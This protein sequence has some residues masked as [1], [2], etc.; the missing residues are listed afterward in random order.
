MTE[1]TEKIV[2][3]ISEIPPG[4]VATYG[5]IALL[6]GNPRGA[7]Q[8]SW[9]LRTQTKKF[10]LPWH[11][12]ISSSGAISIKGDSAYVQADMLRAEGVEVD[13]RGRIDLSVY[14]MKNDQ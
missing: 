6:A 1:L 11:R 9:T 2:R 13:F 14:G 10:D 3:L 12:V 7:R 5:Q 4:Q 8:V